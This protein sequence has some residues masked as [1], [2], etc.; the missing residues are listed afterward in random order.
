MV[1]NHSQTLR[2]NKANRS[3][4]Y[5]DYERIF[6]RAHRWVA[7]IYFNMGNYRTAHEIFLQALQLNETSDDDTYISQ[8]YMGL[9]NVYMRL[10][11]YELAKSY[12]REALNTHAIT[13]HVLSVLGHL[14]YLEIKTGNL[15]NALNILN[16]SLQVA[17]QHD[18]PVPPRTWYGFAEYYRAK[19]VYDSAYLYY[20]LT[21]EVIE[22]NEITPTTM[23]L[24]A[25]VL[26][27]FGEF[28]FENNKPDST[29]YY[30]DLSNTI[31]TKYGFLRTLSANYLILSEVAKSKNQELASHEYFRQHSSINDSVLNIR[32]IA[33]INQ[34]RRL[35]TDQQIEQFIFERRMKEQQVRYQFIFIYV[36]LGI[37][38][39]VGAGMLFFFFQNKKLN[40]ANRLLVDKNFRIVEL[41]KHSPERPSKIPPK[42]AL[43]DKMQEELLERIY[44]VMEDVSVVCDP[45]LTVEKLA[46][47]VQSNRAYVSHVINNT[48]KNNFR[49]FLNEYRIREALRLI[50]ETDFS[51]YTLETIVQKTG[52]KSR[53]TFNSVF[54]EITGVNPNFYLESIQKR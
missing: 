37:L 19:N 20:K 17:Q 21:S 15:E 53:S 5:E 50:S 10:N 47:L 36:I 2:L 12:Y 43:S 23:A 46:D 7:Q 3:A 25:R 49:A 18:E 32:A 34:M 31:A 26:S 33:D 14:A 16:Q 54:K 11:E 9:G 41:Q 24:A 42:S 22:Q 1:I 13:P 28:F 38:A 48:T 29:V 51:K 35:Q 30:I 52:F 6:R 8:I 44:A 27:D 40:F 45:E 4:N 39:L